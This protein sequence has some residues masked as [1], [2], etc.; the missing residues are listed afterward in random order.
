MNRTYM[1]VREANNMLFS[2]KNKKIHKCCKR[3]L[4]RTNMQL[5]KTSVIPD[6]E[7][8]MDYSKETIGNVEVLNYYIISCVSLN[9]LKNFASRNKELYSFRLTNYSDK[10]IEIDFESELKE[11]ML[12]SAHIKRHIE[13]V[14]L[15]L[16]NDML[17]CYSQAI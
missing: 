7:F 11:R 4:L 5:I 16:Q 9:E 15:S 1:T 3:T 13:N 8:E 14:T 6:I 2:L 10:G 12:L 17:N